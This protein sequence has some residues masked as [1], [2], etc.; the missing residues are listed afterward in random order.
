MRRVCV[1]CGS[2]AG[3][4][5]DYA[6]EAEA[7]GRAIAARGMGLVFGGGA[8]GLMGI[9]ARAAQAAGAPV[10]G[11]IPHGLVAREAGAR[12]LAD[13]RIVD[14]MH[15][16]KALMAELSDG[17]VVLPGGF[18]T[19]EEAVEALTWLQLGIHRKGVVFVNTLGFWSRQ[20]AMLDHM[21]AEGLLRA[22]MRPMAMLAPDA[23]A[24]LDALAAFVPPEVPRWLRPGEA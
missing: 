4:R 12:D 21:V 14:S 9:V 3:A 19:L 16:R 11:I 15:E 20:M 24:A 22:E 2:A 5:P 10:T 13:L 1:F 17:F 18:G 23:E 8:V 7:L 6:R